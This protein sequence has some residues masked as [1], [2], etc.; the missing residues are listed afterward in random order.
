MSAIS[1]ASTRAL[2]ENWWLFLLRGLFAIAF[3]LLALWRPFAVLAALVVLYGAYAFVDGFYALLIAFRGQRSWRLALEGLAGVAV[4]VITFF[5]PG[6]T[7]LGLYLVVAGW[8]VVRGIIEIVAA[9]ELRRHIQ[10]EIWLILGGIAS[11]AFGVLL[12][13]LPMSGVVALAWLISTFALAF[14][15]IMCALA[16]RLR[17]VERELHRPAPPL[18]APT[19]QPI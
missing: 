2:V 18:G 16:F 17:R 6:L 3:G 1:V 19:P 8:S 4:G 12:I 5:R 10:G 11:I 15:F 9:I 13:A 14:G 7:A